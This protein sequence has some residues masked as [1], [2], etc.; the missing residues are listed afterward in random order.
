MP[1]GGKK[2][3]RW[4]ELALA[5]VGV[6]EIPGPSSSPAVVRYFVDSVGVKH[7]D[8]VP[9]CAAAVGAWLARAGI[10]PSGSLMARSYE[11]WGVKLKTPRPGA[12]AI[13]ARGRPP[14]GH[15]NIVA[16]VIG[17][18]VMCVGGNQKDAVNVQRYRVSEAV[19]FRWPKGVSL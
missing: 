6:K 15:V 12:I 8:A 17:G 18:I 11:K 4:L 1:T 19:G 3:P 9:W 14:S 5:D 10:K 16:E 13:W 2:P 7:A